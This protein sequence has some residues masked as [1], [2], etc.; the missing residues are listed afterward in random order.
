MQDF[1]T[2]YLG[3]KFIQSPPFDLKSCYNDFISTTP[4]IFVL[5]SGSDPNKV[6]DI[7]ANDMNMSDRLKRIALGQGQGKKAS[8]MVEKGMAAGDW[9]MLQNCHLSISWM[10]TLEQICESFEPTKIN[11]EFRLWLTSMPFENFPTSVLQSDVKITKE[12]PKGLRA[13]LRNTDIKLDNIK[14]NKTSK[15]KEFQK[16]LFGLSFFHAIVIERKK[17]GPLGWN[18]PYEF[19]DTDFDISAAQMELYVDSYAQ[20]PFKVLQQLTSMVNYGG[21]VT[22]DKD[23]RTSDILVSSFI[24]Q[25]TL[26]EEHKFSKS[27]LYYSLTPNSDDSYGSYQVHAVH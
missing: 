26:N 14:L 21:S 23:M 1:I 12:P 3:E 10:P 7:L 13:S 27:G 16:L 24:N 17:F 15:P 8:T 2:K 22:A 4:L 25:T 6:L 18:S 5:S 11:P 19:N 20:I 9:V